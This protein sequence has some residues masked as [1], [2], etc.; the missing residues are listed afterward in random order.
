M[1]SPNYRVRRATL[2]DLSALKAL[3]ASMHFSGADLEKG[4]TEFQVVED[5]D[6]KLLGAIA[7][8]ISEKSGRVHGEAFKD[9]GLAEELRQLLWERLQVVAMNN[10]L[11]RLWTQESAPFWNRCG[12]LPADAKT[13]EKLPR[14]WA[15]DSANWLTVQ[16]RDETAVAAVD[17][18]FALFMETEKQKT[19]R[20]LDY[21]KTLKRVA[22]AIAIVL[23]IFVLAF[24]IRLFQ[25]NP[26]LLNP[27][28]LGR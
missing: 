11:L 13:L 24:L 2:D 10:G 28:M 27:Q 23:A 19:A 25:K 4:L 12:L 22:T 14:A 16:L 8:Q 6:D 17:K 20:A 18:E 21:A 7:L 1:S 9:F 26:Q 15:G 5:T 3:W